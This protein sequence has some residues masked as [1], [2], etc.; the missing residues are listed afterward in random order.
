[1]IKKSVKI[2]KKDIPLIDFS[3]FRGKEVALVEGKIVAEGKTSKEA[4]EKAKRIFPKKLS[5]EI[6]LLFVPKEEIFVYFIL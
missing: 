5:K 1:M 3:K 4:F 6:I 2:Q